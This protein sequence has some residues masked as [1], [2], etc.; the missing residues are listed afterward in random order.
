MSY[1]LDHVAG[2]DPSKL[3]TNEDFD[4]VGCDLDAQHAW[5]NFGGLSLS[6]AYDKFLKLPEVY[7]E[8]FMFM[9][10]S[11]FHYYFPVIERYLFTVRPQDEYDDCQ[12]GILGLGVAAQF[13]WR[14]AVLSP[15]LRDRV[16]KLTT[17]VLGNLDQYTTS[18]PTQAE[19]ARSWSK[20]Q[21]LLRS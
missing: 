20:V 5:G 14:G 6:D 13:E 2:V 12:A 1:P 4:P 9:G 10:C 21:E 8:D 18:V 15:A 16:R 3:P 17:H 19:V 7:Q 11:A